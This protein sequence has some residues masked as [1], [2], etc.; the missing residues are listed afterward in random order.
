MKDIDTPETSDLIGQT[1]ISVENDS[2]KSLIFTNDQGTV[3]EFTHDQNCCET[4]IIEDICGDLNDLVGSPILMA[5]EESGEGGEECEHYTW[6]F[7]KF[8]TIKGA[9]TVRWL[10]ESNGYYS[11]RVDLH[12]YQQAYIPPSKTESPPSKAFQAVLMTTESLAEEAISSALQQLNS[13]AI[14]LNDKPGSTKVIGRCVKAWR[15]E[16]KIMGQFMLEENDG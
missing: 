12:T 13:G 2:N 11:E 10:G 14:L 16:D 5:E 7:Y 15:E 4:V 3:W 6:T 9:V 8:A 1:F